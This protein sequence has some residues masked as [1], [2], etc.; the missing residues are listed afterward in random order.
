MES[1]ELSL[2]AMTEQ[3]RAS[4]LAVR[5]TPSRSESTPNNSYLVKNEPNFEADSPF[6]HQLSSQR[7]HRA[8]RSFLGS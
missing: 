8:F 3:G 2:L 7:K 5:R 4:V 1:S 6:I